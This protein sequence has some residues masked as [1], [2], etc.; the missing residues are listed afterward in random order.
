MF[1]EQKFPKTAVLADADKPLAKVIMM[2]IIQWESDVITALTAVYGEEM[3]GTLKKIR[4]TLPIT[5]TRLKWDLIA[6]RAFKGHPKK[7]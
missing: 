3:D 2:Q 5:R 6:S 7:G 4:R 1:A